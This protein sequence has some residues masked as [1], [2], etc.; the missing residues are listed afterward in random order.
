MELRAR[1]APRERTSRVRV[2]RWV[3]VRAHLA[4][5]EARGA[6]GGGQRVLA[7]RR[8]RLRAAQGIDGGQPRAHA[9]SRA[10]RSTITQ[11]LAKNLYLSPSKNPIRKVRELLIARRLEAELSKQRILELYLNVIE[12]GDGIYGAEAA[13][14]HVLRQARGRSRT[15]GVGA[16]RR[17]RS[18][19]RALLDPGTSDGA[20]APPAADDPAADGRRHA[21]AGGRRR[22]RRRLPVEAPD[23]STISSS[24]RCRPRYCRP[25]R[26]RPAGGAGTAGSRETLCSSA[27]PI[28]PI[29]SAIKSQSVHLDRRANV[30]L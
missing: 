26:S 18:S 25:I 4:E 27:L 15:A 28:S 7:A 19:I 30:S 5:P 10:A 13:R 9:S 2:Q 17:R 16:A 12:W 3:L 20:A 22:P 11:Q 8:R 24:R 6:R 23:R 21:A 1:E 14:A 29:T